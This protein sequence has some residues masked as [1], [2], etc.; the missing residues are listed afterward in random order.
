M[1]VMH[2]EMSSRRPCYIYCGDGH[3]ERGLFHSWVR[4]VESFTAT[5]VDLGGGIEGRGAQ[6]MGIIEF[7][8]GTVALVPI[9]R[10]KFAD[11][12]FEE[13]RWNET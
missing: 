13:F 8:D 5:H 7:E 11:C 4:E 12:R 2:L 10:F 1:A 6:V 3:S 9:T